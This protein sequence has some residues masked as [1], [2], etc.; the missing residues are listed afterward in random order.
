MS[1]A[2]LSAAW[3]APA[4]G[5][6]PKLTLIALA[7]AADFD[8]VVAVPA[9]RVAFITGQSERT[10]RGHLQQFRDAGVLLHL[11]PTP[12]GLTRYFITLPGAYTLDED[13]EL[14]D[15]S[16]WAGRTPGGTYDLVDP[17]ATVAGGALFAGGAEV[18][19]VTGTTKSSR[20][21]SPAAPPHASA[22]AREADPDPKP[23]TA[24]PIVA[25][26]LDAR[27]AAGKGT[28]P[29]A[30]TKELGREAKRLLRDG[31]DPAAITT[32][33]ERLARSKYGP[34]TL[35]SFT[36]NVMN[37]VPEPKRKRTVG[38]ALAHNPFEGME[39]L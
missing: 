1:A 25:A 19:G 30:L 39:E 14:T 17:P 34:R 29:S 10:I 11:G 21:P 22:H 27:K 18:V 12:E 33:A 2:A 8:A 24:Q 6:G 16:E 9:K 15:P 3:F 13:A 4:P 32:A 26:W 20:T 38:E 31:V 36:D 7:D 35:A 37:G 28:P 5:P 23:P